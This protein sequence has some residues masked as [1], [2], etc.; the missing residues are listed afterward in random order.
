MK[1]MGEKI[2]EISEGDMKQ[3][4]HG[5]FAKV[6]EKTGLEDKKIDEFQKKWLE[7]PETRTKYKHWWDSTAIAGEELYAMFNDIIDFVQAQEV[8]QSHVF[9]SLREES[10][11]ILK[12]PETY[13]H[14]LV[15][16]GKGWMDRGM[17][18]AKSWMNHEKKCG[19]ETPPPT[20]MEEVSLEETER[21]EPEEELSDFEKA[22]LEDQ[23]EEE[24]SVEKEEKEEP[25]EELSD[26]EKAELED[27]KEEGVEIGKPAKKTSKPKATTTKSSKPK[28]T[29]K[30][31]AKPTKKKAE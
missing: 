6:Q 9:S 2:K 19:A 29:K 27:T 25:E 30:A 13:F 20:K 8:G 14:H 15:G 11:T 23:K 31:S 7:V 3:A 10:E 28:T 17:G 4:I 26:F 22:E 12:D 21:R 18:W 1:F 24:S 5:L 16:L